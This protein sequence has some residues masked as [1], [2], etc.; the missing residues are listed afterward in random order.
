MFNSRCLF[1]TFLVLLSSYLIDI[2]HS[3][4][5]N[6]MKISSV[7]FQLVSLIHLLSLLNILCEI[8]ME[9]V[10][11]AVAN[12]QWHAPIGKSPVSLWIFITTVINS[13]SAAAHMK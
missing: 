9:D 5:W 4:I 6:K 1:F 11:F 3:D 10:L 13:G 7:L 8:Y 12:Y 2:Y